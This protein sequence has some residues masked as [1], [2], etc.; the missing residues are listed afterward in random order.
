MNDGGALW[1]ILTVGGVMLLALA[2]V[3]ATLRNRKITPA[4][5]AETERKTAEVYR[6]ENRDPS[7]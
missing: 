4:E 1:L 5:H 3:Y 2:L 7:A 6:S